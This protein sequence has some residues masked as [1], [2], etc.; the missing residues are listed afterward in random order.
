MTWVAPAARTLGAISGRKRRGSEG[1]EG[2]IGHIDRKR[3]DR[4]EYREERS[5]SAMEPL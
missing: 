5:A 2:E 4:G 1:V 3:R